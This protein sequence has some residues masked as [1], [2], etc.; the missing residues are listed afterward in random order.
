MKV[1]LEQVVLLAITRQNDE[2]WQEFRKA[3]LPVRLAYKLALLFN[4]M[5]PYLQAFE[6]ARQ[7]T[8]APAELKELLAKDIDLQVEAIKLSELPAEIPLSVVESLSPFLVE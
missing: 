4:S 7:T 1:K 3:K 2:G 8:S 6:E 5:A